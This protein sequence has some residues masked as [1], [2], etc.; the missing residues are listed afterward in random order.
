MEIPLDLARTLAV[1]IDEGT[2]DAA[3]R[4]LRITPSFSLGTVN[5]GRRD[6]GGATEGPK[7]TFRATVAGTYS[8]FIATKSANSD[9]LSKQRN[10]SG[11][12]SLQLRILPGR[13]FG[14]DAQC[15]QAGA[16]GEGRRS[17]RDLGSAG[18]GGD[19][20]GGGRN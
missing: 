14:G 19:R 15:P 9:E 20:G 4:R 7:I 8:E 1:V 16:G 10:I 2:F 3:A 6:E 17:D 11:L 18:H 13:Q 5:L 12:G